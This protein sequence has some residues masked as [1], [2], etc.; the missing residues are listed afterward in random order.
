M[1]PTL[2]SDLV[3]RTPVASLSVALEPAQNVL[4]SLVLLTAVD[5]FSGLD[6]WV[7]RTAA[8]MSPSEHHRNRL[9]CEGLYYAVEPDR[10]W[11]SFPSYLDDLAARDAVELR[12]RLLWNLARACIS[13]TPPGTQPALL[14]EPATLLS[15]A[16]AYIRYLQDY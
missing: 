16:D 14:T 10:R 13:K 11:T 4:N 8:Q 12:D 15:S 1:P 9:V 6:E 7:T 5:R 2:D 3:A